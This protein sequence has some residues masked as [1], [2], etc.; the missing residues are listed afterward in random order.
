MAIDQV[1]LATVEKMWRRE[2]E[3]ATTYRHL[4]DRE[5]D[6]KRKEILI[7]LADQEDHHADRWAERIALSTGRS[8][9]RVRGA[10]AVSSF[11]IRFTEVYVR[12]DGHWLLTAWEATR[13]PGNSA[14]E[15]SRAGLASTKPK[16]GAL[17][18]AANR[19]ELLYRR[20]AHRLQMSVR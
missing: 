2:V 15:R 4:A 11:G 17:S 9:M 5:H 20:N 6:T 1:N 3:A 7:R 10:D 14:G 13:L 16:Q 19:L 12:R 8:E 18:L